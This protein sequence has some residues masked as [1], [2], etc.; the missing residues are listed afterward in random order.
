MKIKVFS[1]MIEIDENNKGIDFFYNNIGTTINEITVVFWYRL[2]HKISTEQAAAELRDMNKEQLQE[3][4]LQSI[5][6]ELDFY[7]SG[8]GYSSYI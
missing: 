7:D 6:D 5:R 2:R 4:V 3:S 1:K 8:Q